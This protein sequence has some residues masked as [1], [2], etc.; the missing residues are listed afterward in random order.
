MGNEIIEIYRIPVRR[1]PITPM[2]R[3]HRI[4]SGLRKRYPDVTLKTR[5]LGPW[6]W[7]DKD[8]TPHVW[9]QLTAEQ[10]RYGRFI[11]IYNILGV[12]LNDQP[13][14]RRMRPREGAVMVVEARRPTHQ[15]S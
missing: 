5:L 15:A 9:R 6:E 12:R 10:R 7:I 1:P 14:L 11:P 4:R 8:V 13:P 3:Y 2:S